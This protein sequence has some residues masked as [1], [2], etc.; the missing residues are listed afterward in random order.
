MASRLVFLLFLALIGSALA[1]VSSQHKARK[2][3]LDLQKEQT[4]AKQ[5]DIEWGQLQLEQGTWSTHARIEKFAVSRLGMMAPPPGRIEVVR[6]PK[7]E[8]P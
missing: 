5:L 8:A 1:V 6:M 7:K 2:L 4:T 3:Y